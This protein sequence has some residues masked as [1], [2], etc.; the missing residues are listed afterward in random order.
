VD[1]DQ[2][3]PVNY[4]ERAE[5]TIPEF[6]STPSITLD[7]SKIKNGESRLIEAKIVN[8]GTYSD[9]EYVFNE[10]YRQAKT[11][12][13]QVGYEITRA[14]KALRDAK[15]KYLLDEYVDFLKENGLKDNA[16]IRDA[17]LERQKEYVA[18]QDRIDMLT[19][20]ESLLEGK[21]KVFENVCRYMRKE[22]DIV[23]RSG[24]D[25]NKYIRR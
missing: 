18:A 19:A 7:I 8:P 21:V 13:S 5:L 16:S 24:V 12:L 6:G 2:K 3:L 11:N 25:P 20:L 17:F 4:T 1:T 9:L 10:G 15:S 22:M 23:I 14:R